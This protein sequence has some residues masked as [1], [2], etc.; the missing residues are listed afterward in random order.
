M[1]GGF[2]TGM[3]EKNGVTTIA[4]TS[5]YPHIACLDWT[6]PGMCSFVCKH[7]HPDTGL[8][9]AK[10]KKMYY[11]VIGESVST[12]GIATL[13]V[14]VAVELSRAIHRGQIQSGDRVEVFDKMC[15]AVD[16]HH[17]EE[18]PSY[19][20]ANAIRV[21]LTNGQLR[22][23]PE[24]GHRIWFGAHFCGLGML[25]YH[26]D[27]APDQRDITALKAGYSEEVIRGFQQEDIKN[28]G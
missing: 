18:Y 1:A 3:A 27:R 8:K 6:I 21:Y 16:T 17:R 14:D 28:R 20:S 7:C 11:C 12:A 15:R 2:L 10:P 4:T 26:D 24:G 9:P 22:T 25:Q 19:I 5:Q 23:F 13:P